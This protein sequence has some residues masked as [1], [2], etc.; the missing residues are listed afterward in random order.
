MTY[1]VLNLREEEKGK[2][3]CFVKF[4]R[5]CECSAKEL[6]VEV[7]QKKRPVKQDVLKAFKEQY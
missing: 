1:K 4:W 5:N 3:T 2:W 7:Y 6:Y